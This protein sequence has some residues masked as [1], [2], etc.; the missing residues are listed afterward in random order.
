MERFMS[1]PLV[2]FL[3]VT[4]RFLSRRTREMDTFM[5]FCPILPTG[6]TLSQA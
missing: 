2:R 3:S 6:L 4:L 5:I 1:R